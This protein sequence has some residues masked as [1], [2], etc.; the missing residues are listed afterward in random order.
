VAG[1]R[2]AGDQRPTEESWRRRSRKSATGQR[3]G[4]AGRGGIPARRG[5]AQRDPAQGGRGDPAGRSRT[6]G[7]DRQRGRAAAGRLG[8]ARDREAEEPALVRL[9]ASGEGGSAAAA[10]E[11]GEGAV[12]GDRARALRHRGRGRGRG[13]CARTAGETRHH[14]GCRL[15]G[16]G[17]SHA[18]P[19]EGCHTRF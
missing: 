4:G 8:A 18:P 15:L 1:R 9:R 3:C 5:W 7:R 11:E 19:V 13:R 10:R 6:W 12:S 17:R 14:Q 16:K 2:A